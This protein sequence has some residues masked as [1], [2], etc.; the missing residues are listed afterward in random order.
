MHLAK[1]FFN[2]L[3]NGALSWSTCCELNLMYHLSWKYWQEESRNFVKSPCNPFSSVSLLSVEFLNPS[4]IC[5]AFAKIRLDFY[6]QFA[7]SSFLI[8][9][10]SKK[11][12][13]D[14][15]WWE[16]L[17]AYNKNP[18]LKDNKHQ[19][20]LQYKYRKPKKS[21]YGQMMGYYKVNSSL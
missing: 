10:L 13:I 15:S 6:N 14:N 4:K 5:N 18:W 17:S 20:A 7:S 19:M 1:W 21:N 3:Q 9:T 2:G 16:L 11:V 12:F 8:L